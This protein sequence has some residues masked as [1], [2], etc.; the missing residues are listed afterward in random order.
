MGVFEIL[1]H[2]FSLKKRIRETIAYLKQE[3]PDVV[4]TIDSPG[5]NF[6]IARALREMGNDRPRLIH[7]VAP[8]VWSHRP[9]RAKTIAGL[10]DQLLVIFPF[11][12]PYFEREGLK[13]SFAGHQIAWEWKT[14]G[15]GAAFRKRHAFAKDAPLLAV[16]P[17]SRNAEITRM[18]PAITG[19]IQKIHQQLPQLKIVVQVPAALKTRIARETANWPMPPLI[20][21][22]HEEK[23]DLFAAAT[24]ALA[25]SGTIALEC[26]L[27]GLPAVITYKANPISVWLVRRL[28]L[29]RYVHIANLMANREIVPELIQETCT[30]AHL[31]AAILPL[32][33]DSQSRSAQL[34]SLTEFAATL[35]AN[36]TMSP[37]DKAAQII[38]N[39]F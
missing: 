16:F 38:L 4:V 33:I 2:I 6:R 30:S 32:L 29:I 25:K 34:A 8:S 22:S 31:S 18:L 13:T 1:P 9:E 5:F 35:G 7:Y 10:Y 17:G 37:S 19:A 12:P 3:R 23:K 26:A 21:S 24:A 27:A 20:L 28:A 39:G 11:E 14:R 36:D 15:D